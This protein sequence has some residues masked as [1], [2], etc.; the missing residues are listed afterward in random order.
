MTFLRDRDGELRASRYSAMRILAPTFALVLCGSV[1]MADVVDVAP[2][3]QVT[4][5]TYAAPINEQPFYGF[6]E[7]TPEQRAS[8]ESFVTTLTAA[9]GTRQKAF[10]ETTMRGWKAITNGRASEAALRFNQAFLLAP[11]QSGVYHG[12][13]VVAQIRFKDTAFADEL[14][15]IARKQPNPLKSLNAD[16]G[17]FLLIANRPGDARPVLEQAV[18]DSPDFGD[19]W[20]NLAYA[21]L[22]TGDRVTACTAAEEAARR[23]PSAAVNNDLAILRS[24]AECK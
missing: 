16:Y 11:E 3:V 17:R 23:K 6:A 14:F 10:E 15:R 24:K 9:A 5:R 1:A 18:I 20:S 7:K 13:A 22:Q 4:K 2:G 21:R 8:D 19:A 12:L